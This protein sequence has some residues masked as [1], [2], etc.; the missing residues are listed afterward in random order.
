MKALSQWQCA[1]VDCQDG[2]PLSSID[3]RNTWI[4]MLRLQT[5][6]NKLLRYA[7]LYHERSE[8]CSGLRDVS[9]LLLKF[10]WREDFWTEVLAWPAAHLLEHRDLSC[11][12]CMEVLSS[13]RTTGRWKCLTHVTFQGN[14]VGVSAQTSPCD[15]ENS[16]RKMQGDQKTAREA[17]WDSEQLANASQHRCCKRLPIRNPVARNVY[18]MWVICWKR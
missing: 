12:C 6:F 15:P 7:T 8:A 9:Q 16:E 11:R 2:S 13:S 4:G 14:L 1:N 17:P 18:S 10:H 5:Y 3:P